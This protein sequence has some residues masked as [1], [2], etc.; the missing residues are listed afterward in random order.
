MEQL[1]SEIQSLEA[2]LAE[3]RRKKEEEAKKNFFINISK[4]NQLTNRVHIKLSSFDDELV[5]YLRYKTDRVWNESVGN[6]VSINYLKPFL[7]FVEKKNDPKY[8][9]VW[10]TKSLEAYEIWINL[11]DINVS[12]IEKGSYIQLEFGPRI[13]TEYIYR[14]IKERIPSFDNQL[15]RGY[16]FAIAEFYLFPA[17]IDFLFEFQLKPLQKDF[18]LVY[19]DEAKELLLQQLERRRLI[20]EL[21]NAADAPEIANP[22]INNYD[23]KPHQRVA[24]KFAELGGNQ[25]RALIAYDMGTGK[26]AIGIALA[27]RHPEWKRIL[28]ICPASLKTNW[29]REIKKFTGQD[30]YIF[31]GVEPDDL[32]I[33]AIADN[34]HRYF[35]INY[36]IIG[37][38][39]G[40]KADK[41]MKWVALFNVF[42]PELIIPDEAH[43]IKNLDSNRSKGVLS[44]KVKNIIPMSGTLIV[45]RPSELWPNLNLISPESFSSPTSF[46]YQFTNN[47]GT[48]R[49]VKQLH[50][51]LSTYMIRRTRKDVYGDKIH[52]ERIP[53]SKE[54]SPKARE[55][56]T[57]IL[58]G[59]YISLRRPD[60]QRNVTSIFAELIR[61]KQ[62]CSADNVEASASLALDA[63]NETEKKVIIFSQFKESQYGIQNILGTQSVVVNGEVKDEQRY[64]LVD[65]FQDPKD[66]IKFW[67]TN[68]LEGLTLTEGH[69][70]I[71]NDIWWTPKDHNQAE[72]RC[73]G[74]DNDPHGGNSYWI[75][76][77]NTIDQ[78]LNGLLLQKMAVF[79]EIIDGIKQSQEDQTGIFSQLIEH[80]RGSI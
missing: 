9:I 32:D 15:G 21:A 55:N 76:N 72:G 70:V 46:A 36:D 27:E 5:N 10:E 41:V 49:N 58:E 37:R 43:Y 38:A 59:I 20:N 22:F 53:F 69:T 40:I 68:I 3:L 64:K 14:Y 73:F 78:F 45:N 29:K 52:I 57:K 19:S 50:D 44:L 47:D 42:Q 79:G 24:V 35:I 56:Y 77:E 28:I 11:P 8:K 25:I 51:M 65:R 26:S 30:A 7:E 1:D 61:C 74:R 33:N 23:L 66:P 39:V 18:K 17:T 75:E 62:T 54:L 12:V 4:F 71:F 63:F 31:S 13:T 16:R 2:Q 34:V 48:A 80:L 67:V 6:I 60:Y